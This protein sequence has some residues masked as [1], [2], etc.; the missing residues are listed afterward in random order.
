ME[1]F[2]FGFLLIVIFF[3]LSFSLSLS[4]CLS[5]TLSFLV[6][7]GRAEG[8]AESSEES[9]WSAGGHKFPGAVQPCPAAAEG[10]PGCVKDP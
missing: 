9:D 3:I 4:F 6:V 8:A 7:S 5:V 2:G 10:R 1:I